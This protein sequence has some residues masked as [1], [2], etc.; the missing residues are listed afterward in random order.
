MSVTKKCPDCGEPIK[1]RTDKKFCSDLCRD[2]FNNKLNSD[3]TNYVR[4]VNNILK[5]NWKILSE[6][7]PNETVKVHKDK[8]TEK[9]FNFH[10]YTNVYTT[11]KGAVYHFC[12]EQGYL[13]LDDGYYALV[14]RKEYVS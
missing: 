6:L 5:R 11:K 9:G 13:P 10:Y 3:T 14:V 1:G 4:N 12:Y 2:A 8:L 7:N